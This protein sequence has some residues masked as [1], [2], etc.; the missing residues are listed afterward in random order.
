MKNRDSI[1]LV[2]RSAVQTNHTA[3]LAAFNN[4]VDAQNYADNC[5]QEFIDRG[6]EDEF[7]F[8]VIVTTFYEE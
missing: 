2:E 8:N 3:I 1:Y 5:A 7:A 4:S 6:F